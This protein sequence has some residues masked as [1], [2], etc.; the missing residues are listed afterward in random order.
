M[1]MMQELLKQYHSI[2]PC[3]ITIEELVHGTATG[4]C[5]ELA[6]F[7]VFWEVAVYRGI[8]DMVLKGVNELLH[9]IG[10]R[11]RDKNH[12]KDHHKDEAK[13]AKHRPLFKV[14][15]CY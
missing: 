13:P 4:K 12:R 9:A 5:P 11:H 2:P 1:Q 14:P 8:N 6:A 10:A 15:I 3:L 7:Y